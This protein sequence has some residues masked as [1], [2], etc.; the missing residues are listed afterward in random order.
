MLADNTSVDNGEKDHLIGYG[1]NTHL[2]YTLSDK[3][4]VGTRFDWLH[5]TFDADSD[6]Y[7]EVSFGLNYLPVESVKIRPELRY[8]WVNGGALPFDDERKQEQF[9]AGVSLF[10]HY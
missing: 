5:S 9:S 1:I 4:S 10:Y 8:D 3:L 2:I 6:D 7:N